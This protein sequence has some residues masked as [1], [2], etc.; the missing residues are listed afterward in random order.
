[1]VLAFQEQVKT[2]VPKID[3]SKRNFVI[4]MALP[5]IVCPCCRSKATGHDTA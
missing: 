5:E 1:M 3:S 2:M 4:D